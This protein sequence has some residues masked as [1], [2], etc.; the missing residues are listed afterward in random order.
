MSAT[1]KKYRVF[2]SWDE[3]L[4]G[5]SKNPNWVIIKYCTGK[6][7]STESTKIP[8]VVQFP[9]SQKYDLELQEKRAIDYATYLNKLDEAAKVAYD[10]IHLVDVLKR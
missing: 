7:S 6:E 8:E 5:S 3:R 9:V 10:Q 2:H 1:E 4:G